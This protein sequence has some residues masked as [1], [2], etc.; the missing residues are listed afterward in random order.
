MTVYT[1]N[2]NDFIQFK[3]QRT[4]ILVKINYDFLDNPCLATARLDVIEHPYFRQDNISNENIRIT[5]PRKSSSLSYILSRDLRQPKVCLS[6]TPIP[7][8]IPDG[9]VQTGQWEFKVNREGYFILNGLEVSLENNTQTFYV[10]EKGLEVKELLE[11]SLGYIA[12]RINSTQSFLG[13]TLKNRY[14]SAPEITPGFLK[15]AVKYMQTEDG[16]SPFWLGE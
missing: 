16:K 7:N 4:G 14:S 15:K 9:I 13:K 3:N 6:C 8:T 1:F 10:S 5:F 12:D 11:N 2:R